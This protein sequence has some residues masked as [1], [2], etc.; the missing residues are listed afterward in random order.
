MYLK[1]EGSGTP[2]CGQISWYQDT[3]HKRN[4]IVHSESDQGNYGQDSCKEN[5]GQKQWLVI[6]WTVNPHL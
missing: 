1:N 2:A 4:C 3:L 6:W 5:Y